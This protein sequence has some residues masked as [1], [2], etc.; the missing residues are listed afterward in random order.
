MLTLQQVK[1]TI[2]EN[3]MKMKIKWKFIEIDF[4]RSKYTF[5]TQIFWP[6]IT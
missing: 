6:L 5:C 1:Y 2:C 4:K 3:E